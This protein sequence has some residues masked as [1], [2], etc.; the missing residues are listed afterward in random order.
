MNTT[1]ATT[2]GLNPFYGTSAAAP[3]AGAIAALLKSANPAL[4]LAQVR[5]LL[6][7]TAID[8]E[9]SGYDNVSGY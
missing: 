6:T 8:I 9:T 2:S 4:T 7:T 3:H 1:L 5:S